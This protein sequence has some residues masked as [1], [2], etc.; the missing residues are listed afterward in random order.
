MH[1][2]RHIFRMTLQ[3]EEFIPV[4]RTTGEIFRVTLS[5]GML[6][7]DVMKNQRP[8]YTPPV[9]VA[10]FLIQVMQYNF[11]GKSILLIEYF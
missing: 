7:L 2:M 5:K 11:K 10:Q 8:N 1:N 6:T 4:V 9:L 3:S